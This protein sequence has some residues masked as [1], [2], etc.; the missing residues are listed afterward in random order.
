MQGLLDLKPD[1]T[2]MGKV[3]A[4]DMPGG[5][6]CGSARVMSVLG[7]DSP[8]A[9][10][11]QLKVLHQGTFT[12]NPVTANAAL[13]TISEVVDK[14]LCGHATQ[15]GQLARSRLNEVFEGMS[16]GWKAYGQLFGISHHAGR[17]ATRYR[18]TPW[19]AFASRSI[20]VLQACESLLISTEST[21]LRGVRIPVRYPSA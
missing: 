14:D 5:V 9:N 8:S 7:R 1:L 13:A 10:G 21:S 17:R 20:S 19:E 6:V 11:L 15:M 3:A 2:C 16:I 4:G 12:G 18:R